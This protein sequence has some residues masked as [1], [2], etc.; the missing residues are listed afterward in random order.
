M[1]ITALNPEDDRSA[2]ARVAGLPAL[3]IAKSYKIHDRI[4]AGIEDRTYDKDASDI[5]RIM[6]SQHAG[7]MA[8]ALDVLRADPS[9]GDSS[10]EM[11]VRD[12][13]A[14]SLAMSINIT[15][16][17]VVGTT[18]RGPAKGLAHRPN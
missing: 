9:A 10:L 14:R 2:E 15:A 5:V 3:L 4:D 7:Q 16:L 11:R 1:R 13:C 18:E 17:I 8:A 12:I 6:Q